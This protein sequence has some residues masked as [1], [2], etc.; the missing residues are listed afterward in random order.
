MVVH[1][2]FVVLPTVP[3]WFRLIA[4]T[5]FVF[6]LPSKPPVTT[7]NA[8]VLVAPGTATARSPVLAA[9]KAMV[10]PQPIALGLKVMVPT[11]FTVPLLLV[12]PEVTTVTVPL[13]GAVR[14]AGTTP[15]TPLPPHTQ[16]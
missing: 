6:L 3:S 5:V 13:P 15:P 11:R 2:V 8:V 1:V 16:H 14:V 10:V 7:A 9:G 4:Q 12:P